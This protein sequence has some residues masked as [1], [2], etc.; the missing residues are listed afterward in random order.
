[1]KE[2]WRRLKWFLNQDQFE[3]E[4]D[5]EMRHHLALKAEERGSAEKAKREFGNIT[6]LKEDSRTVWIGT[7]TQQFTQDIRYGLRSMGAHRVFTAMAVL[8]LALGIGA[9]TAIF[10]FMDAIMLRA[11]PVRHPEQLAIVNWR[12]P[13]D[14]WGVVH[15]QTGDDYHEGGWRICPNFP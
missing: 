9:N 8:S 5:E 2:L 13:A 14:N 4:I 12:Q 6:L 1:M 10:S 7:Y 11:L 3:R 15:S